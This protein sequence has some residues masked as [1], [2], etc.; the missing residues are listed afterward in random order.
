MATL[1]KLNAAVCAVP[2]EYSNVPGAQ[3]PDGIES[4]VEEKATHVSVSGQDALMVA[5]DRDVNSYL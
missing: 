1:L 2:L 4:F 3:W 5:L